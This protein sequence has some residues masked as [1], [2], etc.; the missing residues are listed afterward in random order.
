MQFFSVIGPLA[1][2][3]GLVSAAMIPTAS[4]ESLSHERAAA[5]MDPTDP[6]MIGRIANP[7]DYAS[8]MGKF[9][10]RAEPGF[11]FCN[12][13]DYRGLCFRDRSAFGTCGMCC[14]IT[15]V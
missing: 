7:L 8:P 1:A 3:A 10:K 9:A 5:T 12:H 6:K 15:N 13:A 14:D 4:L 11:Y 2:I